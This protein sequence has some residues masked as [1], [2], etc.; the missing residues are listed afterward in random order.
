[1]SVRPQT[2]ARRERE[3]R[4][5]DPLVV[6][7]VAGV[8]HEDRPMDPAQAV[9][10]HQPVDVGAGEA[11]GH[12]VGT[13][14]DSAALDQGDLEP[15]RRELRRAALLRVGHG[16]GLASRELVRGH[17]GRVPAWTRS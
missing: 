7:E 5:P 17:V 9:M 12:E 8:V 15:V 3:H 16:R 13:G 6:G 14:D 1:M 10:P 4:R 2:T 11:R